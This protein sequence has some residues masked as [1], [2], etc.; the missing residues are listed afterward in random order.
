MN[1]SV[2]QSLK[3]FARRANFQIGLFTAGFAGARR[4]PGVALAHNLASKKSSRG[5]A[6]A[7]RRGELKGD[8]L[9]HLFSSP[10]HRASARY[11]FS[12][13]FK[14]AYHFGCGYAALG[15]P[16]NPWFYLLPPLLGLREKAYASDDGA[17]DR[18]RLGD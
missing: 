10:R 14:F 7:R 4:G 18:S 8:N 13:G 6:E 16:C 9:T 15:N 5:G 11:L 12:A 1:S 3:I 2:L 17:A